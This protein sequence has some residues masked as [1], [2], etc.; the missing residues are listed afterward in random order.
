MFQQLHGIQFISVIW[1]FA[2][3]SERK[4][5][6]E[7]GETLQEIPNLNVNNLRAIHPVNEQIFIKVTA[8]DAN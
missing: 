4:I 7:R 8:Y 5:L 6:C 3:V 2:F 1:A